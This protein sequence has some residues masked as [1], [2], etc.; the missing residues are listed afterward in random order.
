MKHRIKFFLVVAYI[1]TSISF[2]LYTV[3]FNSNIAGWGFLTCFGFLGTIAFYK[4]FKGGYEG[5]KSRD[6]RDILKKII[7]TDS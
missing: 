2:L 1:F 3:I 6:I 5:A 7:L 4:I